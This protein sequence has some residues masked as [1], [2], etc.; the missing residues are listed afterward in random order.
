M[1][2]SSYRK[3][4]PVTQTAIYLNHAAISP[5]STRVSE[6]LKQQITK[7]TD[8]PAD[9]YPV[10]LEENRKLKENF[11]TII[12]ARPENIAIIPNTSTG[13]NWLANGLEWQGGDRI[14]LVE[15]EFPSNIYPFLNLI[16]KGVQIDYVTPKNGGIGRAEVAEKIVKK[17]KI[18]SVSYVQFLNGFRIDAAGIGKLCGSHDIIFS[19]DGIQGVGAVSLDVQ[20]AGIAFLSNGGHKWLMG[21]LGC[22]FMYV[23]PQLMEKLYPVFAGWLSVK[24]SWDFFNYQLEFLDDAARFE[25]G[26]QNFLGITGA[27]AATD[28]LIEV[29][30]PRIEAHLLDMGNYLTGAMK[31]MGFNYTGSSENKQRAGIYSFSHPRSKEIF[32][33]L[34][35]NHIFVSLREGDIRVSPHFYNTR[36]EL[37]ELVRTIKKVL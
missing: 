13:L 33:A 10:F 16:R 18:F 1:E 8:E 11:A 9:V 15:R 24:N 6:A 26:T 29:G 30:I 20:D 35:V 5:Y 17:T 14:L 7:R 22:G 19:V 27:R 3:L 32:D 23:S 36:E 28:L 2:L 34:T 4:F 25:P 37:E 31:D 12:N 21:P